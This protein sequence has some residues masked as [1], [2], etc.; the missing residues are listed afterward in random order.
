MRRR[1]FLGAVGGSLLATACTRPSAGSDGDGRAAAAPASQSSAHSTRVPTSG[2]MP[3]LFLAHGAPPTLDDAAWMQSFAAWSRALA[4]PRAVLMLSAHWT[5]APATLGATRTV[6]LVYD[7]YGFPQKYYEVTYAAPGAPDLAERID[8]LL[9]EKLRRQERGLDHGAFIPLMGLYP[10][11]DVPVLTLSLPTL[12]PAPLFDLGK[13]L[14]PLRDEGV[15]IIGSGFLTH[16]LRE[17]DFRPD[18]TPPAY[19]REFDAWVKDALERN[20]VDALLTYKEKAPAV[21]RVLPTHEHFVPLLVSLGAA[22]AATTARP[23]FPIEGFAF[24]PMTKR[25]V[26]WG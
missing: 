22:Q 9:G 19:A 2:A 6:P 26:Q 18:A 11:A 24:G 16:N 21:A 13:K 17:V 15:L 7:F 12:E 14:G 3:T 4:R 10:A 1:E 5:S 20:D 23:T 8:A 25:S